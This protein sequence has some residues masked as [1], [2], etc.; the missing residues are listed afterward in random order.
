[1]LYLS[2]NLGQGY[3]VFLCLPCMYLSVHILYALLVQQ[4]AKLIVLSL[5]CNSHGLVHELNRFRS[6]YVEMPV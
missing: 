6:I 3:L 5:H 4:N 1:M 2:E